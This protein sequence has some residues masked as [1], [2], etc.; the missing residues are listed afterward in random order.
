MVWQERRRKERRNLCYWKNEWCIAI[1]CIGQDNY[2]NATASITCSGAMK[3]IF[4]HREVVFCYKHKVGNV[5]EWALLHNAENIFRFAGL[6]GAEVKVHSASRPCRFGYLLRLSSL[7]ATRFPYLEMLK[8]KLFLHHTEQY[9]QSRNTLA[10]FHSWAIVALFAS[11]PSSTPILVLSLFVLAKVT[12][13]D[14]RALIS[15]HYVF[16]VLITCHLTVSFLHPYPPSPPP[17]WVL[18]PFLSSSFSTLRVSPV[19][20]LVPSTPWVLFRPSLL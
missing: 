18:T 3:Q 12:P 7:L 10:L 15:R 16:T 2:E 9:N 8:E 4:F 5:I 14:F 19:S 1:G 11:V 6:C 20:C 17:P 13:V